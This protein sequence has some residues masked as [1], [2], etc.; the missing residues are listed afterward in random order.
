MTI[1]QKKTTRQNIRLEPHQKAQL[2]ALA[3]KHQAS[4]SALIRAAIDAFL[5]QAEGATPQD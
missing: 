2:Q 3:K 5:A 4:V 1:P